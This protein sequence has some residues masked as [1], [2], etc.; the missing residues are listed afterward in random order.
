VKKYHLLVA[1][2]IFLPAYAMDEKSHL[3]W[4]LIDY[5]NGRDIYTATYLRILKNIPLKETDSVLHVH[6]EP[7]EDIS[8]YVFKFA[9]KVA[10]WNPYNPEEIDKAHDVAIITGRK[11]PIIDQ[12]F[13]EYAYRNLKPSGKCYYITSTQADG[14]PI[15]IT[16]LHEIQL[17]TLDKLFHNHLQTDYEVAKTLK[18]I[19][20]SILSLK[21]ESFIIEIENEKK[22]KQLHQ[23]LLSAAFSA[24]N[25]EQKFP[26]NYYEGLITPLFDKIVEKLIRT[27]TNRLVFPINITLALL[28]KPDK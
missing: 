28:E 8:A 23:R 24:K 22:C 20:F 5:K 10:A 17:P 9:R 16:C 11:N 15:E 26:E 4:T 3:Q 12:A 7:T 18:Q 25:F 14:H 13:C 2:L 21:H 6:C 1:L 19:G 27:E